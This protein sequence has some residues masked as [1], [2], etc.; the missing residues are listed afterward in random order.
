MLLVRKLA[1]AG[2]VNVVLGLQE[3]CL[4]VVIN[5]RTDLEY[6]LNVFGFS[7]RLG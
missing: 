7:V 1:Y 6:A 4:L 2:R 5:S 3:E